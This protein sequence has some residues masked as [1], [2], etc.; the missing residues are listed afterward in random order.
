MQDFSL[1][2]A[3]TDARV[4]VKNQT[5]LAEALGVSRR[6]L[7]RYANLFDDFPR[8]AQNG[9]YRVENFKKW[10]AEKIACGEIVPADDAG[11]DADDDLPRSS[12]SVRNRIREADL[13]YRELRA[14]KAERELAI[15]EGK[16]IAVETV[17]KSW[18]EAA[19]KIFAL[20]VAKASD[21]FISDGV[22]AVDANVRAETL[23]NEIF[24]NF[25]LEC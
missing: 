14:K 24:R 8:T 3:S 18:T 23:A 7:I 25:Q 19:A 5:E 22:A 16:F 4:Y 21:V 20:I 12:D 10:L 11:D 2:Y 9:L 1:D 17:E 6:T 13:R 15:L